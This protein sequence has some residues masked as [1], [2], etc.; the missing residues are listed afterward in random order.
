MLA[1]VLL[2]IALVFLMGITL[3]V[4]LGRGGTASNVPAMSESQEDEGSQVGEPPVLP[5]PP[6]G[7]PASTSEVAEVPGAQPAQT[8]TVAPTADATAAV[9]SASMSETSTATVEAVAPEV[10]QTLP[11]PTPMPTSTRRP[12]STPTVT[13][14]ARVTPTFTPTSTRAPT[15]TGIVP[16]ATAT[17]AWT[18]TP[19]LTPTITLTPTETLTPTVTLTPTETST[20]PPPPPEDPIER[21]NYYRALAGVPLITAD[22][23]M[24]DGSQK[25]AVYMAA[26]RQLSSSEDSAD[27]LYTPEGDRAAQRG[28]LWYGNG[29]GLWMPADAVDSWM[30]SPYHRLWVLYPQ[31]ERFG[32]GFTEDTTTLATAAVLE[33]FGAW[34]RNLP[35]DAP[36]KYPASGQAGVPARRFGVSLQF[37]VYTST[38]TFTAVTWTDQDGRAV[39]YDQFDPS[40]DEYMRLYG[41][42][43]FLRPISALSPWTTYIVRIRGSYNGQPFDIAWSFTTGE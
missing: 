42:A 32:F 2:L 15:V 30:N 29:I 43:I 26:H 3:G 7:G 36:L 19:T 38:P 27:P 8:G 34:N 25:H 5:T 4:L 18:P 10:T 11:P 9:E 20:P 13:P 33:V 37:P 16:T 35:F 6:E 39:T 24:N 1:I 22:A 23:V 28:N 17:R 21:V 31:A 41:N 12:T 14:T 40:T